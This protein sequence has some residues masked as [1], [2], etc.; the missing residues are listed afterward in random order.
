MSVK[1]DISVGKATEYNEKVSKHPEARYPLHPSVKEGE[2]HVHLILKPVKLFS[3]NYLRLILQHNL[4]KY[5][6]GGQ[7]IIAPVTLNTGDKVL[8]L[9]TGAGI[10]ILDVA[11]TV[12]DSVELYGTDIESSLFPPEGFHPANTHFSVESIISLPADWTGTFSLVH[13]RL[14]VAGLTVPHWKKALQEIHRVLKPGGY[15]ELCEFTWEWIGGGPISTSWLESVH[16]LGEEVGFLWSS[17]KYLKQW[18]V[19][20]GFVDVCTAEA[21]KPIGIWGGEEGVIHRNIHMGA[22][23]GMKSFIMKFGGICGVH[24]EEEVDRLYDDLQNEIDQCEGTFVWVK[25]FGRKAE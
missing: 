13:Q 4:L 9:G 3:I 18:L 20:A 24:T 15:V 21:R 16:A 12:P 22:W 5:Y 7:N 25:C 10:W 17:G 11:F 8:D 1:H 2:R 19:E 23:R 6:F 14:L